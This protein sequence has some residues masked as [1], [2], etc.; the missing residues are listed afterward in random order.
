MTTA[1]YMHDDCLDHVNPPGHP[2]RVARLQAVAAALEGMTLDRR[3][4]P[5][6]EDAEI[7]RCHPQAIWTG[8]RR[9]SP[10]AAARR[11]MPTPTSRRGR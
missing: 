9:R 11:W 8:S 2:E 5:L 4:A 6:A 3:E 7:L 10:R 1:L